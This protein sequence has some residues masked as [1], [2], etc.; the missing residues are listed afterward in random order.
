MV[1]P[2]LAPDCVAIMLVLAVVRRLEG[3]VDGRD[4]DQKP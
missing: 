3:V 1:V 4:D 2:I